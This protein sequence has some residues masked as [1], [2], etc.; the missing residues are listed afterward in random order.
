MKTMVA[1]VEFPYA[2]GAL[3]LIPGDEFEAEDQDVRLLEAWGKARRKTDEAV[4]VPLAD[5]GP[6][7]KGRDMRGR[8]RRAD[9][10]AED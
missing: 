3:R 2:A 6:T 8:Y 5:E 10:R 4:V 7:V 1:M 9:M